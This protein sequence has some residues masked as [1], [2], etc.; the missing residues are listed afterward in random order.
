MVARCYSPLRM[1]DDDET[2]VYLN[3][4][5]MTDENVIVLKQMTTDCNDIEYSPQLLIKTP[6]A[7]AAS[8][9]S[10]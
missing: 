8:L 1:F 5:E 7:G 6:A 3:A 4:Y 10:V 9:L 2:I